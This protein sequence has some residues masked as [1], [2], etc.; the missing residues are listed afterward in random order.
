MEAMRTFVRVA[1]AAIVGAQAELVDVQVSMAGEAEGGDATFRIVG[2][3]DS[4]LREGRER[5]R[6]AVSHGGWPWPYRAVTVNLAPAAARKEGA[7]LDLPI[8]LAVLAGGGP[9]R[10]PYD[11]AKV[12]CVGELTLDGAV[13]P[14][15]G[16]LAAAE[17]AR[18]EG[19]EL[20]W[21]PADNAA[22]AA[23][24]EGLKV[25]AIRTLAEAV[26]HAS[27][28]VPIQAQTADGWRPAPWCG[29]TA[30]IRGQPLAVQA[31]W[32]A[33]AGGHNLLL[34][35]PPGC[36]KTLLARH[37]VDLL[38]PMSRQEAMEASRIHSIAGLLS[39][40][41]LRRRPFRA[42]HHSASIA[43][44]VGGGSNPRPGEVSLAHHGVLFL[45]EMPEFS[46]AALES[47]RQPLEDGEITVAR[48]AGRARFP[49][50]VLL[51]GACNPCPC[52][53]HGVADRCRCALGARERYRAR[54][55]GPLRDRFD[56][57]VAL[58]PVDPDRLVGAEEQPPYDR[59]ALRRA[60]AR[61]AGR[62]NARIPASELPDAV[63][64]DEG[65]RRELVRS[66]RHL[67][68][69]GRGVHRTLR[70]ARTLADLRDV[71][72]VGVE[73]VRVALGLREA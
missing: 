58:R 56:L 73:D 33:A 30:A 1:G 45:D 49:A 70:V 29:C 39:G 34:S 37:L 12:L 63:A 32:V 69:S 22:E 17:A 42:P 2:L 52:G 35:G 10:W 53:W 41:L 25:Y 44:L 54:L 13:R 16:V 48:A 65:A 55:S 67:G 64:P 23:A 36:G 31:A 18:E 26:G 66:A 62:W 72:E 50:R 9:G 20:A 61:Q 15:R 47:L 5:I 19:L 40:G 6:S 14:V 60:R 4:A 27:G 24:V 57:Q 68:L 3:P 11:L 51:V 28:R 46:R 38:P 71:P 8:A 43:G 21:V 7:A 59:T